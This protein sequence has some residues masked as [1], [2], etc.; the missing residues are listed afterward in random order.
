MTENPKRTIPRAHCLPCLALSSDSWIHLQHHIPP[1]PPFLIFFEPHHPPHCSQNIGS[2]AAPQGLCTC[3]SLE[4][5]SPDLHTAFF[6]MSGRSLLKCPFFLP[7]YTSC[8]VYHP[9]QKVTPQQKEHCLDHNSNISTQHKALLTVRTP[10]T[11][12]EW[13]I[14]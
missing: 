12:D 3:Y 14:T 6:L 2:I 4:R 13:M 9:T 11:P 10:Q 7:K 8:R 1:H 5:S